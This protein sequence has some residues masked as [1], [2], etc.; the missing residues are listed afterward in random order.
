M[1]II[2]KRYNFKE[3][4]EGILSRTS[5]GV[6]MKW[7]KIKW[8]LIGRIDL[9]NLIFVPVENIV[10]LS[11]P[12]YPPGADKNYKPSKIDVLNFCKSRVLQEDN[13]GLDFVLDELNWS[14]LNAVKLCKITKCMKLDDFIWDC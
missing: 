6:L 2:M 14:N 7:N 1:H 10:Y 9:D 4:G 8:R 11:Y 13:Q 12:L 3:E 5:N